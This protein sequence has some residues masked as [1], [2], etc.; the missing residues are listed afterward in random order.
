MV[1]CPSCGKHY[2]QSLARNLLCS[3]CLGR[4][5]GM[6]ISHAAVGFR[7]PAPSVDGQQKPVPCPRAYCPLE[8]QRLGRGKELDGKRGCVEPNQFG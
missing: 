1:Q 2:W 8:Q 4:S 7:C 6:D 5:A 3:S